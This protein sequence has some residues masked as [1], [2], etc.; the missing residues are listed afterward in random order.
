M[1]A[2][3]RAGISANV[4]GGVRRRPD[5]A[6][7]RRRRGPRTP[8]RRR[9]ALASGAGAAAASSATR[10]RLRPARGVDVAA[11]PGGCVR[12]GGVRS[13]SAGRLLCSRPLSRSGVE[14]ARRRRGRAAP[15]A[16]SA[17]SAA[18]SATGPRSSWAR[19]SE[20]SGR[21][22]S[23]RRRRRSPSSSASPAIGVW[24]EPSRPARKARSAARRWPVAASWIGASSAATRSSPAAARRRWRPGRSRAASPRARPACAARRGRGG[25]AR[26]W[27]GRWRRR[28]PSASLRSRVCT[29]P[30]NSTTR[31]VRAAV[32]ELRRGG[33]GSRCRRRRPAAGRRSVARRRGDEGVAQ[34]VARQEAAMARPAGCSVGMSFIECTA[35]SMAPA[36]SASSISRVKRPLPPSVGERAVLHPVAGGADRRRSRRRPPAGRAPPSAGPASRAPGRARAGC[37]GCRSG[38]AGRGRAG[39]AASRR[40]SLSLG[41]DL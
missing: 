10:R 29:L 8:P 4:R 22:I 13:P 37:R 30:R 27:R 11:R 12:L 41:A 35:M 31:E 34:V 6:G 19:L 32:A 26:P 16:H 38:A 14:K 15:P 39:R 9:R 25:R 17:P 2:G 18:A 40:G 23:P 33:A 28:R 3:Y 21:R 7:R 5:G 20:P 24:Q 1:A 36:A